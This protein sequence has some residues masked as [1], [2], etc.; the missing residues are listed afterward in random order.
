MT[1]SEDILSFG[2]TPVENATQLLLSKQAMTTRN[3]PSWTQKPR[4]QIRALSPEGAFLM[5]EKGGDKHGAYTRERKK[6]KFN[7]S[8]KRESMGIKECL[9]KNQ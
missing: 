9:L 7:Q 1:A 3:P 5:P 6:T 4:L 8:K 2:A